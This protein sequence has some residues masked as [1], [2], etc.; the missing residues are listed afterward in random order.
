[1]TGDVFRSIGHSY[2][3]L[4]NGGTLTGMVAALDLL[5]YTAGPNTTVVPGHGDITNRAAILAHR[6]ILLAIRDKVQGMVRQGMTVD[7]IVA[8]KPTAE[9]DERVGNAAASADR[10]VRNLVAELSAPTQ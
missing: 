6:D 5:A 10:L 7:Q 8:A 1:M 2:F 9:F 3:D 4:G